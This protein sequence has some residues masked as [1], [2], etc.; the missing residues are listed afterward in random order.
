MNTDQI[1]ALA[2]TQ[3]FELV[4]VMRCDQPLVGTQ[5]LLHWLENG[6]HAGMEYMARDVAARLDINK[7]LP[8]A[9]SAIVCGK[10]YAQPLPEG[11]KVARYALNRDYHKV[12]K[13]RLEQLKAELIKLGG[14]ARICVDSAP[15]MERELA[16]IAGLGWFGKNTM[17]IN[18]QRGS[19]FLIAS[20]LT[21]IELEPDQPALGG[22]GTCEACIEAC[23]TG[24][25]IYDQERWQI[26]AKSC[27]SYYTIEHKG[28]IPPAIDA[29]REGWH[30]GCDICQEVCPF[31]QQRESQ[32]LRATTIKDSDFL[33]KSP[34]PSLEEARNMNE[35]EW[36][37]FT[38]GSPIRRAKFEGFRRNVK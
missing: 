1:K 19:Y 36:D 30:F 4:G 35:H 25:I 26:D 27:I 33:V 11:L 22:C 7:V 17:L 14:E 34:W 38:A 21:T 24:A 29:E 15:V 18:S 20:V 31:N 6:R 3:G 9:K 12:L 28:P 2:V 10:F 23:P 8:G 16:H 5:T 13:K 37:Q 32:P